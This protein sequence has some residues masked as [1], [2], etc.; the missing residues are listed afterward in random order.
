[1]PANISNANIANA[2]IANIIIYIKIK[3]AAWSFQ[4]AFKFVTKCHQIL[5]MFCDQQ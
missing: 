3:K 5:I 1:M 4:T 2:N